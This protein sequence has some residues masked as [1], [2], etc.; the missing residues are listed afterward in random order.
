MENNNEENFI[1]PYEVLGIDTNCNIYEVKQT[2]QKMAKITHP[3]KHGGDDEFFNLVY[4]SYKIIMEEKKIRR[5][6]C[7]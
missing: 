4:K 2:F 6:R 1:S 7:S 5:K 3:D